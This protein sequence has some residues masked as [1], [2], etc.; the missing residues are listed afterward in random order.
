MTH[1]LRDSLGHALSGAN[2]QALD[3][4]ETAC[5]EL[6]CYIG[7]PLG[8]AQQA[9]QASPDMTMGHLL[10]A[11]LNLLGTEPGGVQPARE[12]LRAA[13]ALP[14]DEREQAH[15]QAVG[16]LVDGRW[17]AAGAV[18]EDLSIRHPLDALA[19][20]VGHQVDFFTGH[21]RMLRDRI[22]RAAGAW[23]SGMPGY[24]ALLG[25]YAFG[26][27]ET[28]DYARA[29][30]LGRHAVELEARDGWAWH[31]VAHVMEMQDRRRDGVAWLGSSPDTWSDGSFFAVHNWW[32]LA[33][34]HL[35]LDDIDRV[36]KLV[37][38]RIL[39]S[40]S[41]VVLDMVDAS[42]MLWRLQL[43]GVDVGARW[44][45]LAERWSALAE[46][47]NYA[48]NDLHA[49]MAFVGAGRADDATR[50]LAAQERAALAV[51]NDNVQFLRDVGYDATRAIHAFGQ[52]RYGEVVRLLRP[53]R[54]HAHRFGGSHAQRDV[55]DLTL[56]EAAS[57]DGQRLLADALTRERAA[58]RA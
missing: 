6:R 41:A 53:L 13:S 49:M 46:A 18:L 50:L 44:Q 38:E 48:F 37:D 40:E 14:A 1:T 15:R 58:R 11:Y 27:E 2:A 4:Y 19:L 56:L 33:L 12:A 57:R 51:G 35:G 23:Q 16:H 36:L 45:S 24:H 34:F 39:G 55:I 5:H 22:A 30:A 47:G 52:G 17:H 8:H 9:L 54:S 28:G 20:Q 25:M 21:S 29:E 26:L 42:A 32:H 43:R 7:D 3:H 31:A 10:V